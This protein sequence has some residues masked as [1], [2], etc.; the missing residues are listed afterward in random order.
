MSASGKIKSIMLD[1]DKPAMSFATCVPFWF[2]VSLLLVLLEP[3][4]CAMSGVRAV[5]TLSE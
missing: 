4:A 3:L 1:K 2:R 5:D